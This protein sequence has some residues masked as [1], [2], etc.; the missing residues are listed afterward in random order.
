MDDLSTRDKSVCSIVSLVLRFNC[1]QY[2]PYSVCIC[3]SDLALYVKVLHSVHHPGRLHCSVRRQRGK[4]TGR[5]LHPGSYQVRYIPRFWQAKRPEVVLIANTKSDTITSD[6]D[7]D[8]QHVYIAVCST[9]I[10]SPKE[11]ALCIVHLEA[12]NYSRIEIPQELH[13]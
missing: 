13:A 1:I 9:S 11:C 10:P 3:P 5:T 4:P 8:Q 12:E 2:T 7:L 6:N